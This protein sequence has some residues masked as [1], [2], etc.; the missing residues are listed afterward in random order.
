MSNLDRAAA[1]TTVA[2][3]F[4]AAFDAGDADTLES[5]LAEDFV[6]HTAVINDEETQPRPYQSRCLAG[7]EDVVFGPLR[8]NKAE[9]SELFRLLF[10][11]DNG[12]QFRLRPVTITAQDD[13]VAIEAEGD[14]TNPAN[15]R[16]YRNLYFILMRIR[17]GKVVLYKE[18]QDTLHIYDVFVAN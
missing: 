6:W 14:A 15:G 13:R 8:K 17:E 11:P 5:L 3:A 1:N 4:I 10:N 12:F 16:R 7:L 18:Y 2:R 9:T